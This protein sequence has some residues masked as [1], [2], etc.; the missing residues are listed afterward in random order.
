M[1]ARSGFRKLC[2][3][4]ECCFPLSRLPSLKTGYVR[5]CRPERVLRKV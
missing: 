4:W 1:K 5:G 3:L 2:H